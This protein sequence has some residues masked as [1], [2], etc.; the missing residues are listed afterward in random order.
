MDSARPALVSVRANPNFPV[1]MP[2]RVTILGLGRFGGGAGAARY[3]AERGARVL[4]TDLGKEVSLAG[5]VQSLEGLPIEYHFGSHT[6]SNFA[7]ADLVVVNPAVPPDSPGLRMAQ[8][9]GARLETEINLLFRLCPA[10]IAA[11]TGTN[12]KSTTVALMGE[13]MRATERTTWVGGNLGGSLLPSVDRMTPD[14]AVV[15]EISSFQSERLAWA[16]LGSHVALVTNITPNHLDRHRD[17]ADYARAKRELLLHQ[18]EQD[19]AILNGA[20]PLLRTWKDAGRAQKF[21]VNPEPGENGA[22]IEGDMIQLHRDGSQAAISLRNLLLPGPHNRFNA[23]CAALAAWLLGA[24]PGSIERGMARFKGLP[25]RIEFIAEKHGIRFYNDSI[26]TTPES[27]LVALESFDRPIILIA[28]GSSKNLSFSE[29]GRRIAEH[30]K[31]A[32]LLGATAKELDAAIRDASN[33]SPPLHHALDL[34]AAVQ[35]AFDQAAPGDV[36]LLSPAC[37]SYD[38]F[39]NYVERGNL[40]RELVMALP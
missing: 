24:D 11:V 18:S 32:V 34:A 20:D 13:M 25:D 19:F 2:S 38:M 3:F 8:E 15:L 5:S 35:C 27:T 7:D 21:F 22:F 33:P 6:K 1:D 28:G 14:D 17:M 40:F 26:A 36:V 30:V 23:A 39:R 29:V 16:G 9:S 37:A 31:A 4:V 12:G 10:P